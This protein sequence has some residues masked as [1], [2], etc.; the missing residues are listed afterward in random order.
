MRE[1]GRTTKEPCGSRPSGLNASKPICM[2][3]KENQK[4]GKQLDIGHSIFVSMP[5]RKTSKMQILMFISFVCIAAKGKRQ[6]VELLQDLQ[7][8]NHIAMCVRAVQL[9][10]DFNKQKLDHQHFNLFCK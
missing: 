4:R 8:Y 2:N 6:V 7:I 1:P 3:K 5:K 9:R 10:L